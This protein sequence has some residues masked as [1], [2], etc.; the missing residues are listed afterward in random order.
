MLAKYVRYKF[1]ETVILVT[2]SYHLASKILFIITFIAN[3]I[4]HK[5]CYPHK[6]FPIYACIIINTSIQ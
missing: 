5:E 6:V 1:S 2:Y 3:K 4:E